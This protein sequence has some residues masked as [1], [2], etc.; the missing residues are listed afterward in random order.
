MNF[1]LFLSTLYILLWWSDHVWTQKEFT[2]WCSVIHTT[3][4]GGKQQHQPQFSSSKGTLCTRRG[5][6]AQIM[7][8]AKASMCVGEGEKTSTWGLLFGPHVYGAKMIEV[9]PTLMQQY[10]EVCAG[11]AHGILKHRKSKWYLSTHK[12]KVEVGHD[13]MV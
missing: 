8:S 12:V 10:A 11:P 5:F 2:T 3:G 1:N 6:H 4:T 9:P 13:Q 7:F